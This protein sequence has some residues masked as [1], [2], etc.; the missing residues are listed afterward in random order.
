MMMMKKMY[1][2]KWIQYF[3]SK[4]GFQSRRRAIQNRI[5]FRTLMLWSEA[6][7]AA[8]IGKYL[9]IDTILGKQ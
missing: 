5:V 4:T 8:M 1:T 7:I 3:L 2:K 9:K 6:L